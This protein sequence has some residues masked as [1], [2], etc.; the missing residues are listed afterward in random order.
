MPRKQPPILMRGRLTGSVFIVT[1]Y[2][3]DAAGPYE[4]L[5]KY[6]VTDQF[7]ALLEEIRDEH[8]DGSKEA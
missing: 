1:R 5:E 8:I 6:D 2:K 4:A 3:E 7:D